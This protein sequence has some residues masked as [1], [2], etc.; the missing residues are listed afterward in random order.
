[1]ERLNKTMVDQLKVSFTII[2]EREEKKK[3][4]EEDMHQMYDICLVKKWN[5]LDDAK[6]SW[7]LAYPCMYAMY[8]QIQG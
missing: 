5:D 2:K 8:T 3:G 4:G 1:M 7:N 6:V